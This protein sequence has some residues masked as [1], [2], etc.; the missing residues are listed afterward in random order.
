MTV[1]AVLP[2][3][4]CGSRLGLRQPKLLASV[5][6]QDTIWSLLSGRLEGL[7]DRIH[8]IVSPVDLELFQSVLN[9]RPLGTPVTIGVQPKPTGMGDAVFCGYSAWS[10]A[11]IVLVVWGDQAHVSRGTLEAG[12]KLHQNAPRR[13][14]L[15]LVSLADPYVEYLFDDMGRLTT[16]RQTREGDRCQPGGL[17][18][19]GAFILSTR[20]LGDEWAKYLEITGRGTIT[21]EVNFLPFLVF[22]ASRDWEVL[23]LRVADPLEAKGVNTPADLEFFRALYAG[24]PRGE[25][26]PG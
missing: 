22:L 9:E 6:E 19:V 20:G 7:V 17:G 26:L 5:T 16:V 8:I 2:A 10:Q 24:G 18:D 15:P 4:G 11:D 23:R 1:C 25:A 21:A 14:V 12:I 3:A 13:I